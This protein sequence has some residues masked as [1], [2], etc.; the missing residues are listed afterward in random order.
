MKK[1]IFIGIA[2][3]IFAAIFINVKKSDVAQK[4][5]C[6]DSLKCDSMRLLFVAPESLAATLADSLS[7]TLPKGK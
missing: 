1:Y 3:L 2:L 6:A 5:C 7:D 4:P